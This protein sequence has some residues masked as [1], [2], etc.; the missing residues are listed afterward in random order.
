MQLKTKNALI[1][2]LAK[3]EG[4][5]SETAI[6]NLRE[7]VATLEKMEAEAIV[8]ECNSAAD[9]EFAGQAVRGPLALMQERAYKLAA[10]LMKKKLREQEK[11]AKKAGKPAPA[12]SVTMPQVVSDVQVS[13][14]GGSEQENGNG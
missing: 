13:G 7:V 10:P 9:Y 3:R 12:T 6:A 2:E 8:A 1:K 14:S 11:A 4:K 5:K